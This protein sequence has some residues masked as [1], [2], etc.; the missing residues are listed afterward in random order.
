M[1]TSD[2][3]LQLA[4][5]FVVLADSLKPGH[6]VIDTMDILVRACTT[7]TAATEAGI[8]LADG[9]GTL[10]VIASTSERAIDVENAQLGTDAG[11]CFEA[12]TSGAP[13][14]IIDIA[15]E[16]ER[17]PRFAAI[18]LDRGF[19]AAHA[20]PLRLRTEVIGSI[21]LFSEKP[22]ALDDRETALV[23]AMAEVATISI[24]QQKAAEKNIALNDQLQNALHSRIVIEQAKGVVAQQLGI[25]VDEAFARIRSYARKHSAQ[26]RVIAE[27]VVNH[28]LS[29]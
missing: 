10:H 11:P 1:P 28:Q 5:I 21:N 17:W 16:S 25:P 7:F 3:E 15:N 2:R 8:V 13:V 14:E 6:D 29:I 26:L 9:E 18:A 22:E 4:D 12:F 23:Q 19:R 20:V 24:V 27:Q